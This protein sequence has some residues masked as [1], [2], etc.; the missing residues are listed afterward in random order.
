MTPTHCKRGH[1]L[2][3]AALYVSP[4]GKRVCR[5]C[6]SERDERFRIKIKTERESMIIKNAPS[7]YSNGWKRVYRWSGTE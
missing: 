3:K 5:I 1:E 4:E 6:K 2:N 7:A